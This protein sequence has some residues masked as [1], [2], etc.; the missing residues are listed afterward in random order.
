MKGW[1]LK[2][3]LAVGFAAVLV[4]TCI[5]GVASEMSLSNIATATNE[6]QQM[7]AGFLSLN[8]AK[9]Q[10]S[11]FRLNSHNAGRENQRKAKDSAMSILSGIIESFETVMNMQDSQ[12]QTEQDKD[13][14]TFYDAFIQYRDTLSKI[15]ALEDMTVKLAEEIKVLFSDFD[16]IIKQGQLNTEEMETAQKLLFAGIS[17][18][19]ERATDQRK[20]ENQVA[21][22]E[23]GAKIKS[24]TDRFG[25]AE[26]L[27]EATAAIKAR[28]QAVVQ[29]IDQYYALM[30]EQTAEYQKLS[31]IEESL[32]AISNQMLEGTV[33]K[34]DKVNARSQVI[35][36]TT[37]VVAILIG[38][39]FA[40]LTGRSITIPIKQV[41]AG[42]KDVAEGEGD[43]TKRLNI[44]YKNEVGELAFWFDTFIDKINTMIKDIAQ[45]TL[46]LDESSNQL[47][48]I[49][50]QMANSAGTMSGRATSVAGAA[51]EL[52]TTMNSVAA[53]SEQAATNTNMVAAAAEQ[54]NASVTEIAG[55]SEKARTI[56]QNA[57]EKAISASERVNH[58][59]T[60]AEAISKVTEVITEISEQTNLLALN[61]TIEAARAGEA[62]KGFAVV[63]NEIKE[64]ARQTASATGDIKLK[65][66]DIQQSTGHTVE[67]IQE[68]TKVI[69][70]VN[71]TVGII[72]SAV[73][74]QAVTTRE[75][76]TNIAQ[77]STGIQEVNENVSQSSM[78]STEI[79]ND[80]AKVNQDA[81]EITNSSSVV[82]V[83]ADELSDLAS[84][85]NTVVS[86]F[87]F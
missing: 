79:A 23:L 3:Q 82:K 42:L 49:S 36:Y 84:Q 12:N 64:L 73:E 2:F 52:S 59:G 28:E 32:V 45:N 26:S 65:I 56:T 14:K 47:L 4:F 29:A 70:D 63:A 37:I 68:I 83:N 34:M 1:K 57:V 31:N 86:R 46:R 5:L 33:A 62:G 72:A 18:Y 15:V 22:D 20:T 67:E 10:I 19:F 51:E 9:D 58:L 71:D 25:K 61:A 16:D 74:E 77:A 60:A 24:W 75:I 53:A 85:L 7:N 11:L 38:V 78:V 43:L 50:S 41:T 80:I 87:K 66:D 27:M 55:N 30:A 17:A 81:G 40:L 21:I 35:I 48:E 6:Y 44:T 13:N 69:G 54:M 39:A 8:S 76:A